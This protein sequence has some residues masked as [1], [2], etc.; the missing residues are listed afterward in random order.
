MEDQTI[1]PLVECLHRCPWLTS[2]KCTLSLCSRR[3]LGVAVLGL[4]VAEVRC[5][6]EARTLSRTLRGARSTQHA[7]AATIWQSGRCIAD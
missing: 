1:A 4:A 3:M 2:A 7:V 6:S 5:R